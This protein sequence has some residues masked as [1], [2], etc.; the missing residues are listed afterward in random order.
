MP[1]TV[2]KIYRCKVCN[3]NHAVILSKSLLE[4]R[5]RFPF[6][7]VFLHGDLKH[8]L[9]ILYLD[10]DLQI[11]GAEVQNLTI[12]DD[13]IFSKDQAT[14]IVESLMNEV[15]R[16]RIENESLSKELDELKK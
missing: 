8:L 10:K 12:D 7:H 3:E 6:P 4:G 16:L 2:K 5:E 11:R 9:T 14:S 1:D 15:E 13:N